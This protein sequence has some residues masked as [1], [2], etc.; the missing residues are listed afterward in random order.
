MNEEIEKEVGYPKKTEFGW[1]LTYNHEVETVKYRVE[2][3]LHFRIRDEETGIPHLKRVIKYVNDFIDD[4]A[5]ERKQAKENEKALKI[6][7]DKDIDVWLLM[8]CD[9]DNYCRI[10]TKALEHNMPLLDD[11]NKRENVPLPTVIEFDLVKK[12]VT[13]YA[14]KD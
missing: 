14:K 11:M 10:R 13:N 4:A 2:S 7:I 8:N 9:Y 1:V 12:V 6:I 5:N 3:L